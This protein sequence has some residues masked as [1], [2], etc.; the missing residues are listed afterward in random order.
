MSLPLVDHPTQPPIEPANAL[1]E[2]LK[3]TKNAAS[4]PQTPSSDAGSS[5]SVSSD[6]GLIELLRRRGALTVTQA[7][8]AMKVTP[9]AVRQRLN[10]LMTQN[11]VV[12]ETVQAVRGRPSHRYALTDKAVRQTGDNFADLT[13]ALWQELRAIKDVAIRNAFLKR[14]AGRMAAMYAPNVQGG[15]VVERVRSI[16]KLFS[17]REIPF[18]AEVHPGVPPNPFYYIDPVPGLPTL[19]GATPQKD[20]ATLIAWAC[21]YPALAEQDRGICAVENMVLT[22]L[23][24]SRVKLSSCR[25]DGE[26]CC[27]FQTS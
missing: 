23:V 9:T 12:R 5:E 19:D 3:I 24:G 13:I 17:E 2:E 21:P 26:S 22:E 20:S 18:E 4:D 25:L 6:R 8:R 16:A 15:T 11:L 27:R 10:R 1:S 14:L 7:A